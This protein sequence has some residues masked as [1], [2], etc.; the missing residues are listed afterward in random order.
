MRDFR[1][2]KAMAQTLREAL[3]AKSVSI[4]HSES[5]ELVAKILGVHDWNVLSA[6]IQSEHQP[7]M[8]GPAA[9]PPITAGIRLPTLPLRDIVLFP[10]MIVPLF[11]GRE[12]S[13]RAVERAT[14][15]DQRV[16]AVTQRRAGDDNP[17][18]EGL[19]HVGVAASIVEQTTFDDGTIRL[20]VKGLERVAI[21]QL[22]RGQFLTAEV[23]PVEESRGQEAGAF[24]LS[25]AMLEEF[26]AY[27]NAR[28]P[29]W[30]YAKLSHI[31]QPGELADAVA[32]F[33]AVGIDRRQ[34]LLETSDVIARLEKILSLMKTDQQAA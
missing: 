10:K 4:T 34:D 15:S 25:R 32:A 8:M 1:D 9:L 13:I 2:A 19:Y 21:V 29:D 16:L 23:A 5:L 12:M 14:A 27:R 22:D 33:L 11:M 6:R 26:Q 24:E 30:P 7:T 18:F 17:S 31:R 28:R 20:L 3:K